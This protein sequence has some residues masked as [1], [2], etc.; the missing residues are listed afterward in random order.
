MRVLTRYPFGLIEKGYTTY[1]P[2]EI[3]V[4][5]QLLDHVA[6]PAVRPMQGDAAPI[7]PTGRGSEFAGSVRFYREG[8]E[9]RDIH[10]KRTA[11]RGE[12]VVRE[13]EQDSSSL[14]TL[15]VNNLHSA[16]STTKRI[17]ESDS[18][19]SISEVATAAAAYLTQGVSVQVQA[20]DSVSPLVAGGT[21]PDPIWR[22]L[23]LA[24][25][26]SRQGA[27]SGSKD[28]EA[29][30]MRFAL[31]PQVGRLPLRR[32]RPECADARHDVQ[33]L[34]SLLLV[35]AFVASWFAE[36]P[37]LDR[38]GYSRF[39]NVAAVVVLLVQIARANRWGGALTVGVQYAAFPSNLPPLAPKDRGRLPADR[40]PR[41][42]APDRRHRA[43]RRA[44]LR[45]RLLRLRRRHAVDA[46]AH[47]HPKGARD[48]A[49]RR[50]AHAPGR[51]RE[52]GVRNACI[53]RRH[54]ASRGPALRPD[55][56]DVL[57]VSARRL[58][59]PV[60]PGRSHPIGRRLWRR[61]RARR[62]RHDPRR[63]HR[64]H[65]G[66]AEGPA[67]HAPA[68]DRASPP[69][70]LVRPLQRGPLVAHAVAGAELQPSPGRVHR[71]SSS[72]ARGPGVRDHS[73]PH[74]RS[75]PVPTRGHRGA[76]GPAGVRSGRDRYR[77]IVHAPG[78]DL[79][80]GG[81]VDAPLTYNAHVAP[82]RRAS[83]RRSLR[84][85]ANATSRSR[86]LRAHRC[87]GP[88]EWSAASP[89]RTR[90]LSASSAT[91]AEA[92]TSATRSSSPTPR[93][94]IRFT[95]SCSRPRPATASTSPPRWP[96]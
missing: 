80:Y 61:R 28:E 66:Q 70:H 30:R 4:F 91:S 1:L 21:P 29:G 24:A 18:R 45:G 56:R 5:P 50:H 62:L 6:T 82:K 87:V 53:L 90:K 86:G 27:A 83:Q 23:A 39:W 41:V 38:P 73:R 76:A 31:R 71:L 48:P 84:R 36:P 2:D 10:W 67:R 64:R 88:R 95:S 20:N 11:S 37:L 54:D 44:R 26:M 59:L 78:L 85:F 74:G 9:A 89:I 94:R 92:A 15:T 46:R 17:G 69:R 35:V 52:Q 32:S 63:P 75:G 12:L 42:P 33:P 57:R 40:D 72:E 8:D 3:V 77:R 19:R 34:E 58:W 51:A 81:R 7:H 79:R 93:A 68:V 16:T 14:V 96:S 22:F 43:V 13:H 55:R 60:Q 47:A 25:A 49:R 65:A